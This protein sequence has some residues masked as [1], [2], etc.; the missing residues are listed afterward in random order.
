M[1]IAMVSV[2]ASP[3]AAPTGIDGG[4][5]VHVAELARELGAQGHHVTIYTH[6]SAPGLRDRVRMSP[7]VAVEHIQAGPTEP[8][9]VQQLAVHT[10]EF[11]RRLAAR[12]ADERPDVIHAHSWVS[13]LAVTAAQRAERETRDIPLVQSLYGLARK[14]GAH[15][16]LETA[17]ARSAN[18]VTTGGT[19][20]ADVLIQNG[21][22]RRAIHIVPDGVDVERFTPEGPAYARSEAPRLLAPSLSPPAVAATT[23]AL[24]W[25]PGA[26]F[27]VAGGPAREDIET[28][29][30]VDRLRR[31]AKQAGVHD[32]VTFLGR[33]VRKDLPRLLRSADLV[34]CA[35]PDGAAD[36]APLEAMA[37][38]VPVVTTPSSGQAEMVIDKVTGVHVSPGRPADMARRVRDLLGDSTLRT[39]YGIAAADRARSRYSWDRICRETLRVFDRVTDT[40]PAGGRGEPEPTDI[41][42]LLASPA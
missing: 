17:L 40:P 10:L 41:E 31:L 39:A 30:D 27:V 36:R 26:E 12:L 14:A 29:P 38:G 3:L 9:P 35:P 34:V 2:N 15:R 20:E 13:G 19:P 22:P 37:C 5:D 33:V 6:K 8:L 18:A 7:G 24:A 23:A 16:R 32:R 21:V 4:Q 1:N 11:G 28:D 42:E 25:I